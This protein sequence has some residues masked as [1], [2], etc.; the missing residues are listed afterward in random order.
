MN[1]AIKRE[2]FRQRRLGN[3]ARWAYQH[4]VTQARW[5][6]MESEG[7]VRLDIRPDEDC[8]F[9]DLAGDMFNRKA[10]PDIPESR[11]AKEEKEYRERI[12]REGVYGIVGEYFDGEEWVDADSVWGFVGDDWRDSGYDSD[13]KRATMDALESLTFCPCCKRPIKA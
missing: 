7:L 5:D 11:M 10:N 8:G 6:A 13:I 2:Y 12:D 3:R 9:D 4:A 1:D